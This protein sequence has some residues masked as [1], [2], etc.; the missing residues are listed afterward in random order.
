MRDWFELGMKIGCIELTA[1]LCNLPQMLISPH[2]IEDVHYE[3]LNYINEM[4]LDSTEIADAKIEDYSN[5]AL[6]LIESPSK[7]IKRRLFLLGYY[8]VKLKI[9]LVNELDDVFNER[10]EKLHG[11]VS[12]KINELKLSGSLKKISIEEFREENFDD[13][14]EAINNNSR[15]D[16]SEEKVLPQV[17]DK[18]F[19]IE[20]IIVI[21]V[22]LIGALATIVAAIISK[23]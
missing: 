14:E 15:F 17:K 6:N 18:K 22:A 20:M 9:L 12:K 5:L 21:V 7:S 2:D 16:A 8:M 19:K 11:Y 13:I 10:R 4:G 3:I 1:K 23:L